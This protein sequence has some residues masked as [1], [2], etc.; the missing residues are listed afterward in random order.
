LPQFALINSPMLDGLAKDPDGGYAL[1]IQ[2]TSPGPDKESN[3]LPAPQ[4]PFVLIERLYWP[5]PEALE[6]Q[7]KPEQ[8]QKA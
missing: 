1:Y 3:W 7:W 8:P 6:G 5:K 2:N 4:G